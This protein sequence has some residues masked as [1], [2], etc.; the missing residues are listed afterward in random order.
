MNYG[1][2]GTFAKADPQNSQNFD[3]N[4]SD[5]IAVVYLN[6]KSGFFNNGEWID[7]IPSEVLLHQLVVHA[8]PLAVRKSNSVSLRVENI[9]RRQLDLKNRPSDGSDTR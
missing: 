1:A 5:I 4:N 6:L 8:I 7:V 9:I 3:V 2:G